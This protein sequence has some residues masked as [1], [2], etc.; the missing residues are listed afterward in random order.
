MVISS[1]DAIGR[2]MPLRDKEYDNLLAAAESEME[3]EIAAAKDKFKQRKAG[4]DWIRGRAPDQG[5]GAARQDRGV[6]TKAVLEVIESA[7][8]QF[9]IADVRNLLKAQ[10]HDVNA[11]TLSSR[12]A[13][14]VTKRQMDVGDIVV[15]AAGSGRTAAVWEKISKQSPTLPTAPR[16]TPPPP[17]T[18]RPP[19]RAPVPPND[20]PF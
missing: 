6:I 1:K 19:P 5:S 2:K 17:T 11:A 3:A 4:L 9:S 8:G 15:H 7:T 18:W 14:I 12:F 10:G 13:K 20:D 16:R